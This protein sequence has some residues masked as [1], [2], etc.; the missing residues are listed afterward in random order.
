[1]AFTPDRA[2]AEAVLEDARRF[3]PRIE[4]YFQEEGHRDILV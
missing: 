2:A 1:V 4:R 3:V